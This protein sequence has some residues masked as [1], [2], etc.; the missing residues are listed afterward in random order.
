M[1]MSVFPN[2]VTMGFS[3]FIERNVTDI[4]Q[5]VNIRGYYTGASFNV[6]HVLSDH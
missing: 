6:A 4:M 5:Y 3:N 2:D 1:E